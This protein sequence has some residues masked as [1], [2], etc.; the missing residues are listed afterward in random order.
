MLLVEKWKSSRNV[1]D[2]I[3]LR[4]PTYWIIPVCFEFQIV[5]GLELIENGGTEYYWWTVD[6]NYPYVVSKD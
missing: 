5:D 6:L 1:A 4:Y 3:V 2:K